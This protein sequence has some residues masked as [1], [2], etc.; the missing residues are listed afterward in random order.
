M[1][2][3]ED[4]KILSLAAASK[5]T[6]FL[7]IHDLLKNTVKCLSQQLVSR[8]FRVKEDDSESL[9]HRKCG[10]QIC[11]SSSGHRS[12][13]LHIDLSD[14]CLVTSLVFLCVSVPRRLNVRQCMYPCLEEMA[15][16]EDRITAAL[17]I[18]AGK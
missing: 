12:F 6:F 17:C 14:L 2:M 7:L 8:Y 9:L 16:V 10:W 5:R 1:P 4:S 18:F 15:A 11:L 13:A 3:K